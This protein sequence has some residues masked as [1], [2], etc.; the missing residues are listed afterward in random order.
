M[1]SNHNNTQHRHGGGG[2]HANENRNTYGYYD[3]FH[4]N[5]YYNA[6][7]DEQIYMDEYTSLILRYNEFIVNANVL[8]TRMEQTLRE[9]LTRTQTRQYFYF[10]QS[11]EFRNARNS[12]RNERVDAPAAPHVAPAAATTVAPVGPAAAPATAATA[13][14]STAPTRLNELLP[15][16]LSRYLTA[17][18]AREASERQPPPPPLIPQEEVNNIFSMLYTGP[19]AFRT[20]TNH[21]G[22]GNAGSGPPTNDQINRA[23]LNTLFSNILSP[24]NATCPITRDEFDDNTPITMIRGCNHIFNRDSLRSWFAQHPTCPLCRR[25]IREY[26]ESA[27]HQEQGDNPANI[28]IDSINQN[29]ITFSYDLPANYNYEDD[30]R[31]IINT[32]TRPQT[33]NR[34]NNT[35]GGGAASDHDHDHDHDR[36]DDMEEVD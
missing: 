13:A 2:T 32:I 24:V 18:I 17:N 31:H 22:T 29:H 21:T 23:T 11:E 4:L 33:T 34:I 16:L 12:R 14:P 10:H 35:G 19:I 9:N 5:Q 26:Q 6:V 7:E 27:A 8:F 1:S 15:R 3:Q 28:S 36:D 25:D 30:Y 20:N